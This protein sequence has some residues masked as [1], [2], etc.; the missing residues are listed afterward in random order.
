[1]RIKMTRGAR[2]DQGATLAA[3][4]I[5][6]VRDELAHALIQAGRAVVTNEEARTEPPQATTTETEG[7]SHGRRKRS[8]FAESV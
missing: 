4:S 7:A 8:R 6:V 1:M 3:G 5:V 2:G